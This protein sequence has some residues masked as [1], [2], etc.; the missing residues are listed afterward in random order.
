MPNKKNLQ[1]IPYNIC[2]IQE[3]HLFI[4]PYKY[5]TRESAAKFK[6]YAVFAMTVQGYR[7]E[8]SKVQCGAEFSARKF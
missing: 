2:K 4:H 5:L 3:F 7:S 6:Q 1:F 8:V